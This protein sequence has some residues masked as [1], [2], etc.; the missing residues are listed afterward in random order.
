MHAHD[1]VA[2]EEFRRE[3]AKGDT[4]TKRLHYDTLQDSHGHLVLVEWDQYKT[5]DLARIKQAMKTPFVLDGKGILPLE[6]MVE[7]DIDY[8]AIGRPIKKPL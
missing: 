8:H 6:K 7:L 3:L 4:P 2:I 1:P 5:P